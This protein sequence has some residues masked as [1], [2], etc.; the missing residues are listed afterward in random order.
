MR[1]LNHDAE[2]Y[3][4]LLIEA[5]QAE[6]YDIVLKDGVAFLRVPLVDDDGGESITEINL[7]RFAVAMSEKLS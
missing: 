3:Q 6:G 4:R 2:H 7:T 1:Q 5:A